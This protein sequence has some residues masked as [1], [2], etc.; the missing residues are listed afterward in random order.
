MMDAADSERQA[1]EPRRLGEFVLRER[2]ASGGQGELYRA[3]Q[4]LLGRDAVVK[5]LRLPERGVEELR[6][7]FLREAHI[8]SH[9]DHPYAAHVYAFGAEDETLWIAMEYVR[10]TSMADFL[11]TAGP[12]P[13]A[14]FVP[15]FGR[16]AQV[17]HSAHEQ[18][19]IHRDIK[20]A[21]VM[22][23]SR[24]GRLLPKLLD[25]GIARLTDAPLLGDVGDVSEMSTAAAAAAV[26]LNVTG[27]RDSHIGTPQYMAPEQWVDPRRADARTD[28]YALGVLCHEMLTG[29][30]PFD[31]ASLMEVARAH[32]RKP[33]PPLGDGFPTE[34]DAVLAR[35]MAKRADDRFASA[36]DL[37][38]AVR[39]AAAALD[40][41]ADELPQL[42]AELRELGLTLAPGPI[43]E[44][45]SM[46]EAARGPRQLCAAIGAAA[47][48]ALRMIG[49]VALAARAH[50]GSGADRDDPEVTRLLSRLRAGE[51]DDAGWLALARALTRPFAGFPEVHPAPALVALCGGRE[52]ALDDLVA[53]TAVEAEEA[54]DD[55]D[56]W[57]ARAGELV[58]K[59]SRGLSA[60]T[61]LFDYRLAVRRGDRV[62]LWVGTRRAS[63]ATLHAPADALE[64]GALLL[65]GE[66]RAAL[67]LHPVVQAL[68]PSPGATDELFFLAG[69]GRF[70]AR[71]VAHPQS[72]E[73][74]DDALWP[75]LERSIPPLA[76]SERTDEASEAVPYRGL[77][78]FTAA[79]ADSFVGREREV[80]AFLNRLRAQ[81]LI[82]VVGP[83][84]AGK[85]SFVQA[86]VLANLPAGWRAVVLRPGA[87]PVG[88][89]EARRAAAPAA[90]VLVIVVDQ[91]EEVFTLCDDPA[92]RGRFAEA[93]VAATQPGPGPVRVI[94]TLRDDFLLRAQ[95][96]EPLRHRL[97]RGLELLTTPGHAD[98]VRIL[99]E[100][101]RRSGYE[102][103]DAE[104]PDQM[105]SAV[106]DLPGALPLLS[107]T[108]SRLWEL[109]DR[110]VKRLTRRAYDGLGGVGG[111]L[112]RHAEETL[113]EMT[114]A[115]QALVRESFRH[116]VTSAGTRAVMSRHELGQILG[117]E[118]DEVLERLIGARLL[119]GYEGEGG[120]EQVEIIHEA[121]L[122]SWPRLVGWRGEDAEHV[123]M[124]EQLRSAARQWNER[125][126]PSGLLWRG[127]ALAEYRA[128]RARSAARLTEIEETFAAASAAAESRSRR[129]RRLAVAGVLVASIASTA[130]FA[131]LRRRA[132]S[133]A[134]EAKGRVIA[135]YEEQGRQE[136]LVGRPA[137]AAAYLSAAYSAGGDRGAVRFLLARALDGLG[138]EKAV[139]R[140]GGGTLRVVALAPS[141][142]RIATGGEDGVV[143]LWR[144]DG[145]SLG[146][147]TAHRGPIASAAFAPDGLLV[148][149]GKDGVAIAWEGT[150]QRAR[151]DVGA[152]VRSLAWHPRG[153]WVAVGAKTGDISL[154][155]PRADKLLAR[156]EVGEEGLTWLGVSPDGDLVAAGSRKG[157]VRIWQA[158]GGAPVADFQAHEGPVWAGTFSAD[159]ELLATGSDDQTAALWD[160][161]G[162]HLRAR[163]SGHAGA[164]VSVALAGDRVLTASQDGTARLW[165]GG[166]TVRVLSGHRSYVQI[167]AFLGGGK[168][169]ATASLDGSVRLW[170]PDTGGT[171]A[172][173]DT[174]AGEIWTAVFAPDD[175]I[176]VTAGLDGTSRVF[177]PGGGVLAA[178]WS[179]RAPIASADRAGDSIIAAVDREVHLMTG[180]GDQVIA[181]HG[182]AVSSVRF[183]RDGTA[184][185]SG[186]EDGTARVMRRDGALVAELRQGEPIA[187]AIF[188]PDGQR[189]A[190]TSAAGVPRLWRRDGGELCRFQRHDKAVWDVAFSADGRLVATASDDSTA[191][192]WRA[193]GCAPVRSFQADAPVNT[194]NFTR[195]QRSLLLGLESGEMIVVAIADGRELAR[196]EGHGDI[197]TA[198]AI[199]PDGK[200]IASA[201]IDGRVS[202]WDAHSG[203][204]LFS[205]E[206][207]VGR[208]GDVGF[209]A[210]GEE[211]FSVGGNSV[212]IWRLG[213]ERRS[214]AEVARAVACRMPFTLEHDVVVA[215]D[216][217]GC[218]D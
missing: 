58:P 83:S 190:T 159:G 140:H 169:V 57:R 38:E 84:G 187:R 112:G 109:R 185:V 166:R 9:L 195:D 67:P 158:G 151:L 122:A 132:Q 23:V 16:L 68:A 173:I 25:L 161:P 26:P 160:L 152:P 145:T 33:V 214:P 96:L 78:P 218:S 50:A 31:G 192:L 36:L 202:L 171:L 45:L 87:D 213:L 81:G 150:R 39:R 99:V 198:T 211:L 174:H 108:A 200:R 216:A 72:F 203:S 115:H 11:A 32:A 156:V 144:P 69:N 29:R 180:A 111:A 64:G 209:S 61:P 191:R 170:D 201:A 6:A 146:T 154:W 74:F 79:D 77:A 63:R 123:R 46:L 217:A 73:R 165:Q 65:D 162:G 14:R 143:R 18:G 186:S 44:A 110:R 42:P 100:P 142:D 93:L 126:R 47:R 149:G 183:S 118:A 141:A 148:T 179:A 53:A 76:A 48:T 130:V 197:L 21:N 90:E 34:L 101:A 91:F 62:E 37:A 52:Q 2:I 17:V 164:V 168:R 28:V 129:F 208:I 103:E 86:G 35:A 13:L 188:S 43:A 55:D 136:L 139:L 30:R 66:G 89:L 178:E 210:D 5:I 155:D 60:L 184:L 75:A 121:L 95:A 215:S 114:P 1:S 199:S 163:L 8:A 94:L 128:W 116:L 172:D 175:S 189:V 88:A 137:R 54:P 194:V 125:G 134:R 40:E 193:D 133:S 80:E 119:V 124:R 3:E 177:A 41:D 59:L 4:P 20:P 212:R 105:A 85:S 70:G 107:F 205:V 181:R 19:I 120:S 167:A 131:G 206:A 113:A 51:L 56:G 157:V 82:A 104:L 117:P 12:M 22:M 138:D 97:A 196:L 207:A 176:L 135:L 92:V 7:R 106:E 98:L 204:L 24:A 182:A 27:Q 15:V 153:A 147:L 49:A 71:L 127:D 102:F 10:G